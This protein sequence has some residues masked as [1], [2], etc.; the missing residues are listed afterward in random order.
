MLAVAAFAFALAGLTAVGHPVEGLIAGMIVGAWL[1]WMVDGVRASKQ[2][3]LRP[4]DANAPT[5]FTIEVADK[6]KE[7]STPSALDAPNWI[8]EDDLENLYF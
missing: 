2:A 1:W 3:S 7:I 8:E 4:D 5:V 6:P